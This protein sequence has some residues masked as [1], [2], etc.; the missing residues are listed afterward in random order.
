[1]GGWTA[2]P[3]LGV[4]STVDGLPE[5]P[6]LTDRLNVPPNP[7][8]LL[9]GQGVEAGGVKEPGR[10]REGKGMRELENLLSQ[11][12]DSRKEPTLL[13]DTERG[14]KSKK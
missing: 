9:G 10:V 5:L 3:G 7:W 8:Q 14:D 13:Q 12:T 6:K 11:E 1:M 2:V 4:H